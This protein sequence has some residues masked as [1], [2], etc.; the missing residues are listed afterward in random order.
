MSQTPKKTLA[1]SKTGLELPETKV[2]KRLDELMGRATKAFNKELKGK[3]KISKTDADVLLE[4]VFA[5]QRK[6][7]GEE[8]KNRVKSVIEQRTKYEK[9]VKQGLQELLAKLD[10]DREAMANELEGAFKLL[11]DFNA[12]QQ[13]AGSIVTNAGKAAD[14]ADNAEGPKD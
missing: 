8:F 2:S 9:L 3:T 1:P 13:L 12:D 10:K 4:E 5:E 11:E 14:E 7:I 6:A